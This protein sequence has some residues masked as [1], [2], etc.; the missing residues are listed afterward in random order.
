MV[1]VPCTKRRRRG[2]LYFRGFTELMRSRLKSYPEK[3]T[4]EGLCT[5]YKGE[6]TSVG[7][8]MT[9]CLPV[10]SCV[11]GDKEKWLEVGQDYSPGGIPR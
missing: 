2:H 8:R 11:K 9:G 4:G 5:E 7:V 1:I 6:V 10:A 3:A